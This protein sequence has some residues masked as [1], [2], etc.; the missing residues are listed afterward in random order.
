MAAGPV[1][2]VAMRDASPSLPAFVKGCRV[3]GWRG[4]VNKVRGNIALLPWPE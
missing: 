2:S 3:E 1:Q 4:A